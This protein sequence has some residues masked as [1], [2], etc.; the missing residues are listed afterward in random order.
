M[1]SD[2]SGRGWALFFFGALLLG[3]WLLFGVLLS[4]FTGIPTWAGLAISTLFVGSLA[5]RERQRSRPRPMCQPLDVHGT[6]WGRSVAVA[7]LANGQL[8]P[9]CNSHLPAALQAGATVESRYP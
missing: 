6:C 1:Y 2:G 7:K 5:Y 4:A 9:M 3:A 8:R